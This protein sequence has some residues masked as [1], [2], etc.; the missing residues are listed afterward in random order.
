MKFTTRPV[1]TF[2]VLD[3]KSEIKRLYM[4]DSHED[5]HFN[6]MCND[7]THKATVK[8]SDWDD[9]EQQEFD[10]AIKNG[11]T[12]HWNIGTMLTKMAIDGHIPE[13]EYVG[14]Y[15]Y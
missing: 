8:I 11:S 5:F 13:G 1:H 4:P 15:S 2:D 12:G 10:K 7:S 14:S 6:E 3:L 9:Y